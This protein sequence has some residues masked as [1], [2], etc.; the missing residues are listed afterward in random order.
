LKASGLPR[1][2]LY[3]GFYYENFVG[4]LFQLIKKVGDNQYIIQLG[5]RPDCTLSMLISHDDPL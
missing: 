5:I 1:T 2:S 3:T 4:D